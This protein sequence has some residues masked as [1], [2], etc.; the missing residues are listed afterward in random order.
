MTALILTVWTT[1]AFADAEPTP[2]PLPDPSVRLLEGDGAS[3][4]WTLYIELESG[5]RISQR[6]LLTNAGPGDHTAVAVGHLIEPGRAPYRYENG[7]RRSRWTLSE[8]R[9][10]MDIAAS[11]LDLHRPKGQL[12]ITKD[13][14]E[15]RLSFDFSKSD[16]SASVPRQRLPDGL[17]IDILAVAAPTTGSIHA[18]WMDA[19][20]AANGRTWM[21][22]T[23]SEQAEASLLDRRIDLYASDGAK[24][25]YGLQLRK[26]DSYRSHFYLGRDRSDRIIES[27]INDR[28]IWLEPSRP[29]GKESSS[30]YPLP[31]GFTVSGEKTGRITLDKEWLRFD[32]LDVIPNPFRWF[33]RRV[34]RPQEV[35]A[36]AEFD[37]T[38]WMA[39]EAPS[40][41]PS[42][43]N[44]SRSR[45][46]KR[47]N[48]ETRAKRQAERENE[49]GSAT[50]SVTGVASI[51]FMNPVDR[52]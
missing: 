33:I 26:G 11:H 42:D 46:Q 2:G 14:I 29:S 28:E 38:L 35:W 20:L 4:Y 6:F 12:L 13:D 36:D 51:T 40:H 44:D 18:P 16:L 30:S 19:P 5:H 49:K 9:L 3:E 25:F 50:S 8:D 7:R 37:V 17:A 47:S 22:H 45:D 31:G 21:A 15:I 41:L 43:A 52:R 1:L 34:T 23:W 24:S 10:F 32:P 39:S 27:R 48:A